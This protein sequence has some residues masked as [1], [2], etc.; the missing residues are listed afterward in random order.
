MSLT[1]M[2][3]IYMIVGF[4][5]L[6]LFITNIGY[7]N[8][9]V[10]FFGSLG[11]SLHNSTFHTNAVIAV[12]SNSTLNATIMHELVSPR[13]VSNSV[14]V[15]PQRQ[16]IAGTWTEAGNR[17]AFISRPESQTFTRSWSVLSRRAEAYRLTFQANLVGTDVINIRGTFD[18]R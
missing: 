8:S 1:K 11:S 2:K 10:T 9:R 18:I 14:T 13:G 4:F 6:A 16:S 15:F 7:A 3:K 5:I 12:G 17:H